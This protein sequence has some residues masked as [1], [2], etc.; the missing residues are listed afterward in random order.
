VK[1]E[2]GGILLVSGL[3]FLIVAG[4]LTAASWLGAAQAAELSAHGID[5]GQSFQSLLELRRNKVVV[6]KW[7]LSC[8]AAALATILTYQ[9]DDTVPE[10]EIAQELMRR[11]EYLDN[12]L[13][14]RARQ[15]F[16]ML[17]LKRYVDGRGYEGEGLGQLTMR[18]LY[19]LAPVIVPV[20]FRGY[21]HFVVFRGTFGNRV[22][23]ADPAY[24]NRTMLHERF[25]EAWPAH[26]R[27]GRVGFVVRRPGSPELANHLAPAPSDFVSLR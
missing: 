18:D 16:S 20:N 14:V 22:L 27:Y 6:Q 8:G 26:P 23:I 10:R 24:G 17:D 12:P 11:R 5:N 7:D 19:E 4:G 2:G 13:L 21:N 9:F 25:E 3:G 15:G 1:P